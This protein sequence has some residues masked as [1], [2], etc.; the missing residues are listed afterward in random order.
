MF[1]KKN[2]KYVLIFVT[3]IIFIFIVFII[4][5]CLL[6]NN[7]NMINNEESKI[8]SQVFDLNQN[9]LYLSDNYQFGDD[10]LYINK[11]YYKKVNNYEEYKKMKERW[12]D[13][14]EMQENDFEN[15]FVV[16]IAVENE[17][18]LNMNYNN[19]Y[20]KNDTLYIG[21]AN[22]TTD[23]NGKN[24]ISI[25][26]PRLYDKEIIEPYITVKNIE[27]YI[28]EKDVENILNNDFNIENDNCLIYKENGE[29]VNEELAKLFI[30]NVNEKESSTIRIIYYDLENSNTIIDII[31]NSSINKFLA[32]VNS[33][34]LNESENYN[35]LSVN[36]YEFDK[37]DVIHSE[38]I[39]GTGYY[40]TNEKAT[41]CIYIEN[42]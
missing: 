8:Q 11:M 20:I 15:Y 23:N 7:E 33:T 31:Y 3:I 27:Q 28:Y 30:N 37:I 5:S 12:N 32:R 10:M 41:I 19:A 42:N 34:N 18:M 21:I 40:L 13:I 16:I 39:N 29:I 22:D 36:Y 17:S 2:M 35:N 38:A 6:K 24:G 4:T 26:F 9:N 1:Y 14:I 25:K